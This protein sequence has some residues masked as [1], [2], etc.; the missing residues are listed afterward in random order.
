MKQA[1]QF[2]LQ[3]SSSL[4]TRWRIQSGGASLMPCPPR[5]VRCT[6]LP[7]RRVRYDVLVSLIVTSFLGIPDLFPFHNPS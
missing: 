7:P 2:P 6:T 3:R 1:H 4:V 5:W